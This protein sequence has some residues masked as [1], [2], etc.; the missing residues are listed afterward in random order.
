VFGLVLESSRP[1]LACIGSLRGGR[2]VGSR[3][4]SLRGYL[5][6]SFSWWRHLPLRGDEVDELASPY[7]GLQITTVCWGDRTSPRGAAWS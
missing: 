3:V 1:P 5:I 4:G 7:T 2:G 6:Q